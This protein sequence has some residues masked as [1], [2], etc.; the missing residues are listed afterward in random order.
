MPGGMKAGI[1][2]QWP[3]GHELEQ[4][5]RDGVTLRVEVIER[6]KRGS[7]GGARAGSGRSDPEAARAPGER[8]GEHDTDG[9]PGAVVA[10]DGELED[11]EREGEGDGVLLR[12]QGDDVESDGDPVAAA[13]PGVKSEEAAERHEQRAAGKNI[14]DG[15]CLERMEGEERNGEEGGGRGEEAAEGGGGEPYAREVKGEVDGVVGEGSG[16]GQE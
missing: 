15:F 10:R 12:E 1:E 5:E 7:G 14:S 11:G 6:A 4:I 2:V 13:G 3:E 9:L 16:G 8:R